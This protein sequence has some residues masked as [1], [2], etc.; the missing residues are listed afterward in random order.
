MRTGI[1]D[2]AWNH[3]QTTA[4]TTMD[5]IPRTADQLEE[6]VAGGLSTL[7][8]LEICRAIVIRT[9][10]RREIREKGGN[11]TEEVLSIVTMNKKDQQE[12]LRGVET[13]IES[14]EEIG[15][16]KTM[17]GT[18][19]PTH[20]TARTSNVTMKT[21]ILGPLTT[22]RK[23]NTLDRE[24]GEE[25]KSTKEGK[26]IIQKIKEIIANMRTIDRGRTATTKLMK[27]KV[28]E[29][30]EKRTATLEGFT[31]VNFERK[32]LIERRIQ[33]SN[34]LVNRL[35][36]LIERLLQESH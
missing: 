29:N 17:R 7:E 8:T 12:G 2:K 18:T 30:R 3:I 22:T 10:T 26:T 15:K 32:K 16:E 27:V 36:L 1:Q 34:Q 19:K 14:P 4:P 23:T 28:P 5:M 11:H 33:N 13:R 24:E 9:T 20:L 25:I 6:V 31:T 21:E 35:A